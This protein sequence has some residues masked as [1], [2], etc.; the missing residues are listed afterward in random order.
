MTAA[1]DTTEIM[2]LFA[3]LDDVP[4]RMTFSVIGGLAA[5]RLSCDEV[6]AATARMLAGDNK[7]EAQAET[8]AQRLKGHAKF[9]K[10]AGFFV[11]L[12]PDFSKILR[13]YHD[14]GFSPSASVAGAQCS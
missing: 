2:A 5:G 9:R 4:K 11:A 12:D 7:L 6:A 13:S 8:S 1:V 10:T 3:G 14:D